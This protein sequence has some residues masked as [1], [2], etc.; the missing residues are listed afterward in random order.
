MS[1]RHNSQ[2]RTPVVK[3]RT[4]IK[5]ECGSE[6]EFKSTRDRYIKRISISRNGLTVELQA[7]FLRRTTPTRL[8]SPEP[9]S[10]RAAGAGTGAGALAIAI[11]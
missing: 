8:I 6:F 5:L 7:A 11:V 3:N 10:Q 1:I 2:F 4:R 9:S